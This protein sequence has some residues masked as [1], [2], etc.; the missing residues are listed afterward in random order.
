MPFIAPFIGLLHQ[1]WPSEDLIVKLPAD[2]PVLFLA[3]EQDE[4]VLPPHMK[5]LFNLCSSKEKE[6]KSFP[7]GTH[8]E[9]LKLYL[10]RTR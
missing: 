6:W 1:I 9:S 10:W 3:G 2:Y 7:H 8:S 4:L 5:Q